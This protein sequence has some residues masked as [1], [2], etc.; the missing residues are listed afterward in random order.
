MMMMKMTMM[1]MPIALL[2]TSMPLNGCL[3]CVC[4]DCPTDYCDTDGQ[5]KKWIK[6]L[7]DGTINT[8]FQCIPQ[9]ELFPP[10]RPIACQNSVSDSQRFLQQCCNGENFCNQNISLSFPEDINNRGD[11]VKEKDMGPFY[12]LVS[13]LTSLSILAICY[14][15]IS[16]YLLRTPH[17]RDSRGSITELETKSSAET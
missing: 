14:C 16:V 5:C 9:T 3:R 11:D 2:L 8:G 15:V 17:R 1:V 10:E 13:V 6:R 7:S 4:N 12:V